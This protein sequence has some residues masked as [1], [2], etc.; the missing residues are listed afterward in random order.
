[1]KSVLWPLQ[2]AFSQ[3]EEA[4]LVPVCSL[5]GVH[6]QAAPTAGSAVTAA[7]AS[8]HHGWLFLWLHMLPQCEMQ[9]DVTS[10]RRWE[11]YDKLGTFAIYV[12]G[13]V[14]VIQVRPF[15]PP[16][17]PT[18]THTHSKTNDLSLSKLCNAIRHPYK[19]QER[20]G[21]RG[22]PVQIC[23]V[24]C[25]LRWCDPGS[26]PWAGG[27][28]CAGYWRYRRSGYWSGRQGDM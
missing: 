20:P 5:W 17:P 14:L 27:A 19:N 23:F 12:I 1:M 11:A 6:Q 9:G 21:H 13:T 28:Q 4:F 16:P 8:L 18:H 7:P 2:P 24:D 22:V 25:L 10:Q 3:N 15:S 26:G